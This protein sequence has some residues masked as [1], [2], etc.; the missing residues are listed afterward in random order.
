MVK[1]MDD[2]IGR[3]LAGSPSSAS[4]ATPIVVFTSDNGG[5]RFSDTWPFTGKKTE[6]LEGGLR[7]P[8]I[9]RWPGMVSPGSRSTVPIISMDWLPT[10]VTAGGGQQSAA[11][12]SDGVD[13]WPALAGGTLPDRTL[14][15]RYG[16]KQ[17][18]A[19]RRG[20]HKYL[21]INDNEFMFDVVADPL[22]RA[23][24]QGPPARTVC[25]AEGRLGAVGFRDAAR[26]DRAKRRQFAGQPGGSLQTRRRRPRRSLET[27]VA[28]RA[29]RPDS[30]V[31]GRSGQP[32]TL[33][34]RARSTDR[35]STTC[36]S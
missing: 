27:R 7:I 1:S 30:Q 21:K 3:V 23:N 22:E 13:I 10:F 15:W 29:S 26:S 11:F 14:F 5:E 17:Q 28:L 2:N 20:K 9:V 36:R 12:P 25:R 35:P 19:V 6:L 18:R 4:T 33:T 16:N 31:A 34:L 32:P 24:P 8:A